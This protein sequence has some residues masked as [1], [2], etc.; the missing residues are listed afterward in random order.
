M[1]G[2]REE[3]PEADGLGVAAIVEELVEELERRQQV[4]LLQQEVHRA[5]AQG[6]SLHVHGIQRVSGSDRA[7]QIQIP[8]PEAR[9]AHAES[10]PS[11][12]DGDDGGDGG[13]D[14][15]TETRSVAI[16][17]GSLRSRFWIFIRIGE[18]KV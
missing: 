1:G 15:G 2:I 14:S 4:V 10:S 18:T 3:L 11:A 17:M 6:R 16:K 9:R 8:H 13:G 12:G 5:V 7:R